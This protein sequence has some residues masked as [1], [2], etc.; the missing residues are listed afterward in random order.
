M[1]A[2]GLVMSAKAGDIVTLGLGFFIGGVGQSCMQAGIMMFLSLVCAPVQLGAASA[3]MTVFLNL[4]AFMCSA[5]DALIGRL[6]GDTLY[7]PLYIGAGMFAV[8]SLILWI[9]P[10]FPNEKSKT[11]LDESDKA[12]DIL[13]AA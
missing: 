6:T 1:A 2:I 10:P 9:C 13:N 5:W 11:A 4:G 7:M 12:A 8:I 3:L